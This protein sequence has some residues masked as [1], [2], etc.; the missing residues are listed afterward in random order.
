MASSIPT[1][2]EIRASDTYQ[3]LSPEDQ[4]FAEREWASAVHAEGRKLFGKDWNP[5]KLVERMRPTDRSMAIPDIMPT[6]MGAAPS[7]MLGKYGRLASVAEP[8]A[9]TPEAPAQPDYAIQSSPMRDA[10][11]DVK[12]VFNDRELKARSWEAIRRIYTQPEF[13]ALGVKEQF[14]ITNEARAGVGLP[15]TRDERDVPTGEHKTAMGEIVDTSIEDVAQRISPFYQAV[16]AGQKGAAA[17]ARGN[18]A[19]KLKTGQ[20]DQ[21]DALNLENSFRDADKQALGSSTFAEKARSG[22]MGSVEFMGGLATGGLMSS[23]FMTRR[24]ARLWTQR[25]A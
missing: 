8:D 5:S 21:E 1:L 15:A 13:E 4:Q 22:I 14:R 17:I 24:I 19:D 16:T 3:N 10:T 25:K 20:Y 9:A 2:A 23:T 7:P 11:L 18:I 12:K 6:G